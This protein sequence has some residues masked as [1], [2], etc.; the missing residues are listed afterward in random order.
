MKKCQVLVFAIACIMSA[1]SVSHTTV[2]GPH[3]APAIKAKT[4]PITGVKIIVDTHKNWEIYTRLFAGVKHH[5]L[6]MFGT[7]WCGSC[8]GVFN[9][10]QTQRST[11]RLM[12]VY[13]KAKT[14]RFERKI[15]KISWLY[16]KQLGHTRNT[17]AYPTMFVM[18]KHP[19]GEFDPIHYKEGGMSCRKIVNWV[20]RNIR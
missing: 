5:Y 13:L 14:K 9:Y 17:S 15:A 1:C 3:A 8:E 11:K 4:F 7:E 10:L 19:A 16:L 6:L 20:N 12:L 2:R 18:Q